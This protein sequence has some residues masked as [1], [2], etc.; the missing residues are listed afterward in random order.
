MCYINSCTC[1]VRPEGDGWYDS[2]LS[3]T[4]QCPS[5]RKGRNFFSCFLR[6]ITFFVLPQRHNTWQLILTL[7]AEVVLCG[8]TVDTWLSSSDQCPLWRRNNETLPQR[9][10]SYYETFISGT[11]FNIFWVWQQLTILSV[12][13]PAGG[14]TNQTFLSCNRDTTGN[15]RP[16]YVSLLLLGAKHEMLKRWP[17]PKSVKALNLILVE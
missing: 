10:P 4:D 14:F 8:E 1:S 17:A 11:K 3:S 9:D 15:L 5:S 6:V 2:W 16:T 7:V 13:F 12:S